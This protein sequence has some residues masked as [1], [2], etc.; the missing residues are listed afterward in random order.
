VSFK[1]SLN[2]PSMDCSGSQSEKRGFRFAPF[3]QTLAR[4]KKRWRIPA[5]KEPLN[6]SEVP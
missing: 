6:K 4:F 1:E 3:F 2:N 5:P